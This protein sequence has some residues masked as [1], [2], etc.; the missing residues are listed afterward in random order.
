EPGALAVRDLD[1]RYA[2]CSWSIR[3]VVATEGR[4]A[5]PGH[6][7]EQFFFLRVDGHPRITRAG[8]PRRAC[9]CDSQ[10]GQGIAAT[11]HV[12]CGGAL[13]AFHGPALAVPAV[14]A[15]GEAVNDS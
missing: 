3:C 4:G 8:R 12:G 7:S 5:L 9:L 14:A 11:Q 15:L 10:A 6:Q 2:F 1:S 13:L